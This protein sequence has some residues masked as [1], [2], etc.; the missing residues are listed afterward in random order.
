MLRLAGAS[1]AA[2]AGVGGASSSASASS[3]LAGQ[4]PPPKPPSEKILRHMGA[5]PA[6]FAVRGHRAGF[7]I[8]D[9]THSLGL[10]SVQTQLSAPT[11]EAAAALRRRLDQYEM[12]AILGVRLPRTEG[13]VEAFETA[14]KAAKD[15]NPVCLHVPMTGRRYE[16][17]DTLAAFQASFA[18]NK[19]SVTLAEPVLRKYRLK[20]AI[21]N[22]KGWRAAEQAEWLKSVGSEYIGVCFDFGNNISL[23]EDPAESLRLLAPATFYCH[24]KDM[25]VEAYEDGFLLSEVALGDG[26][27][28]IPGMVKTLRAKDPEMIFGLEMIARDPLKIPVLTGKYWVS[29]TDASSP[30]PG[31]DLAHTLIFVKRHPPKTPLPHLTGLTPEAQLHLED[32]CIARSIEFARAHLNL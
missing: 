8:V 13:D 27:L 29:F 1:M 28:D 9:Y 4:Q 31:V 25:A 6:G 2:A 5:T 12:R 24:L 3:S 23:C 16:D 7:D 10:G 30:L 15:A 20:L 17:F 22:H 19:K 26:V 14:V 21:E 32:D 11:T 18:Q